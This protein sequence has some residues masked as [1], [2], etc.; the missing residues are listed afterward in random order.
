MTSAL[1]PVIL[2]S[3]LEITIVWPTIDA[4]P[5]IST[6]KFNFAT[7]PSESVLYSCESS[8]NSNGAE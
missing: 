4:K 3:S 7:S 8:D 1:I 6:P 2:L 5:L